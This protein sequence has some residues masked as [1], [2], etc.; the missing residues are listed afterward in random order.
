[1]KKFV[2][3][4]V[5]VMQVAASLA[6]AALSDVTHQTMAEVIKIAKAISA[7]QPFL[8]DTKLM[9]YGL[10]IYRA[11]KKYDIDPMVLI[12]ITQQETSFA[13][14][15]RRARRARSESARSARP[16]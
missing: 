10:G 12:G 3:H 8:D 15:F 13:R 11:A 2:F 1:M 14:T 16:G 6:H 7:V 9:E 5:I 4:I